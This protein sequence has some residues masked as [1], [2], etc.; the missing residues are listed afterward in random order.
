MSGVA[1]TV[2]VVGGG[3]NALVA[4]VR[5]A[6][7]GAD[8]TVLERGEE[9]GGCL[10]TQT[11]ADGVLVERGAWEH[12]GVRDVAEGLGLAEV[13]L[14]YED[15]P[16]LAG[17]TFGDGTQRLF[18]ADLG[19]TLAGLRSDGLGSDAGAYAELAETAGTLFGMLD[20]FAT[21]PTMTQ[22]AAALS[23]LRGGDALFRTLTSSAQTVLE[24]RLVDPYL[25][26][27]LGLYAS[28]AQVPVWAP[29]SGMFAFLLPGSHGSRP[30]RPVGGS[31]ALADALVSALEAAG[32]VVRTGAEVVG[33]ASDGDGALVTLA[34]GSQLTVDAV[35]SSVDLARTVSW[36][37]DAAPATRAAAHGLHSGQLN[38]CEL[39]VS[40]VTSKAPAVPALA[41]DP[42][43]VWFAID[44]HEDLGHSFGHVLAG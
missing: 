2:A 17:F 19:T 6:R 26:S 11:T 22:V 8:V 21:P 12:G 3:H 4:A 5:L 13:G 9:A 27:A 14:T 33:L 40:V 20:A 16:L 43:A 38:V 30:A 34:D 35:V 28:H 39:T 25:R 42:R 15:H 7:A 29:G 41:A 18:H 1:R 31:R 24:T 36:L 23:T 32:G 44:R 10:W 37:D